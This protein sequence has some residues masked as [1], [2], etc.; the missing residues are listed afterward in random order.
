[1]EAE[2]RAWPAGLERPGPGTG[3]P[4]VPYA[5]PP[6]VVLGDALV[7]R[8]LWVD[9]MPPAG[10]DGPVLGMEQRP[11]GGGLNVSCGLARLGIPA[12]L[13]SGV[14]GDEAGRSLMEHL[15]S[16]GVDTSF[17]SVSATTG[18]V[19]SVVD[20]R[21]ERTMFSYRGA[22]ARPV[23]MTPR[24]RQALQAAAV[25]FISGY[26]LQSAHQA[27]SYIEA[28]R[29][30]R[31]AGG[32]VAFDPGPTMGHIA[33][34]V[35]DEIL[36]LTDI[37]LANERELQ[38]LSGRNSGGGPEAAAPSAAVRHALARVPCTGAKL[39][40]RGSL[41]AANITRPPR[42]LGRLA[43]ALAVSQSPPGDTQALW[44]TC[45]AEPVTPAD[46][47]GAGDAFDAGFLAALLYGLPPQEWLRW[48]NR[49]A[50]ERLSRSRPS[51]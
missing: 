23:S 26:G 41:L 49:L 1:M 9:Q 47:T 11:G 16:A 28:V 37:L 4:G 43:A 32:L 19:L 5:G 38:E 8:I 17:V 18:T 39:G 3:L 22:A 46:T 51:L 6:V 21:G 27:A 29:V 14:G 15:A 20:A 44:L 36:N 31:A 13:V 48:G 12:V 40:A 42:P 45:P 10:G 7:D 35:L 50:A 24:L 2:E 33:A 25:V 34:A 30:A